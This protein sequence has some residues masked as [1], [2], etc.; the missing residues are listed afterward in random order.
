MKCYIAICVQCSGEVW[1]LMFIRV[2]VNVYT[3]KSGI[4]IPVSGVCCQF[5]GHYLDVKWIKNL[6]IALP[7][8]QDPWRC[9]DVSFDDI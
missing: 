2:Y 3:S 8:R 5:T 9:E 7:Q 6:S 1:T 4:C